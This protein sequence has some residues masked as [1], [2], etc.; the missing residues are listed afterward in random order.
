[1]AVLRWWSD[2]SETNSVNERDLNLLNSYMDNF[3][4]G[5]CVSNARKLEAIIGL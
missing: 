3:L 4:E 2:L 5:L 1:M